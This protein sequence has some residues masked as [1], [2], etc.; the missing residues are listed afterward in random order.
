MEFLI[1]STNGEKYE[2]RSFFVKQDGD[3]LSFPLT[4]TSNPNRQR[5]EIG[6]DNVEQVRLSGLGQ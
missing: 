5:I 1:R 4:R 2:R 6:F 3:H